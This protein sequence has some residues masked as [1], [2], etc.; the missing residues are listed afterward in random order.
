MRWTRTQ[1][2][3]A[4]TAREAFEKLTL[5]DLRPLAGL[6]AADPP[7]RKTELVPLLAGVMADPGRVR[8]LYGRL[9]PLSQN[10]V[11]VA[12]VDPAGRLDRDKFRAWFGGVPR[13]NDADPA[14]ASRSYSYADQRKIKPVILRLFFPRYD[15]LPTDTRALLREFVPPPD[16]FA[17]PT[18]DAPP[19][20]H[21]LRAR[22]W[23]DPGH[24]SEEWEEPVR[25]RETAAAAG[26]DVRTVL[27]LIEA[28]KVRVTDKKLVPTEA[29]RQAVA[30][31]LAGGDFYAPGD[32]GESEYDPSFD[33]GIRSFAWPVLVQAGGLAE[34]SGGALK[35]TAAGK[36]ALTAP[37]PDVLRK[38]WAAWLKTRMFD[39]FA[40][41]D[42]IKGQ[43]RARMSAAAGRRAELV[44]GLA[45][46][47]VGR[48][49]AVE[50]FFRLLRAT[51]REFTVAHDAHELYIAE[52]Y[53]GNFG[54]SD[55]HAWEQLQGRFALAFLFEYAA[56]L[57]AVDVAYLPP[58]GVRNDFHDRW[59]ADDFSC[60]SR[61]DGL[62]YLRVNPLGAWLLGSAD[63]YRPAAPTRSDVLRVLANLDVVAARDLPAADRLVLERFADP[64]SEGVWKLSAAKVLAVIEQGG[65][66]DEL[67]QFLAPRA[68]GELP[69]TVATF[70]ADLRAKAG[71]L[72]DAGPARLIACADAHSAAELAADRGLKGKCLR[73]GD[74]FVVVREA[75]LD[76]VRK[77]V[78]KLGYVWPVPA[79]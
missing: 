13:L 46:C 27:R 69:G 75:D 57:G 7:K 73:A 22:D 59:G 38:L 23:Y 37:P 49:F 54:Y 58:Q 52:H 4:L 34:K 74:R 16:P 55:G 5:D 20:T 35:L 78:R 6:L 68:T 21:T 72:T 15:H 79:D 60:L 44:A 64:A 31:V 24:K 26:A 18:R 77:A 63:A 41:V 71:R 19:E 56:T 9:D 33:V 39:E 14:R 43:G 40:R 25:V 2:E 36:K 3:E 47:P 17:V 65:S 11:R 30:G 48:W 28:G 29:A 12:A 10:A 45:A 51:G 32:A 66:V 67:E 62:L 42:A 50:D 61:Y 70:L 8:D 53:Y 1:A 76:A